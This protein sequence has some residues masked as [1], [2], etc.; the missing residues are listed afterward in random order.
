MSTI[1][2]GVKLPELME[3][4]VW[5]GKTLRNFSQMLNWSAGE[6]PRVCKTFKIEAKDWHRLHFVSSTLR[7]SLLE[8]LLKELILSLRGQYYKY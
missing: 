7:K 2:L 3:I 5:F 8:V 1:C 4:L 6:V